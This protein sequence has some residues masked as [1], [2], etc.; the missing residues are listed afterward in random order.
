MYSEYMRQSSVYEKVRIYFSYFTI[1]LNLRIW[2]H[3]LSKLCDRFFASQRLSF[4]LNCDDQL[5]HS[6]NLGDSAWHSPNLPRIGVLQRRRSRAIV[7][8]QRDQG[9]LDSRQRSRLLP[10][11]RLHCWT[12]SYAGKKNFYFPPKIEDGFSLDARR[13]GLRSS[14]AADGELSTPRALQ[15]DH[16]GS[17]T[18]HVPT[19]M[20]RS[21][22]GLLNCVLEKFLSKS[23]TSLTFLSPSMLFSARSAFYCKFLH[24]QFQKLLSF[25]I[26]FVIRFMW[27][28]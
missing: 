18:V 24:A 8:V 10:R 6:V 17:R 5:F 1:L 16:D 7:S 12:T 26:C 28:L 9:L 14:V 23:P 21:G 20:H 25:S 2:C 22:T 3:F 15:T 13:R 19:R 4:T 11:K 27:S